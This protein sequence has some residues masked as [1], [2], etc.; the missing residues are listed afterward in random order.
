MVSRKRTVLTEYTATKGNFPTITLEILGRMEPGDQNVSLV[1]ESYAFH[2]LTR[3]GVTF[4][5][6]SDDLDTRRV[7]FAFLNELMQSFMTQYGDRAQTAIAFSMSDFAPQ[8]RRMMD[9]FNDPSSDSVQ[10]VQQ[11]LSD[12][13]NVMVR[14]IDSVLERGERLEVLVDKSDHLNQQAFKFERSSRKLKDAM[15][16]RKVKIY[17]LIAFG[18]GMVILFLSMLICNPNFKRCK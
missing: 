8:L 3:E 2:Y 18:V 7:A 5:C 14:N 6:L 11:R 16:W 13:K 15:F 1:H 4:L 9:H 10:A 17:L 12:V